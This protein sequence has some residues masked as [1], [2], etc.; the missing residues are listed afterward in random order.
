MVR[1]DNGILQLMLGGYNGLVELLMD[2]SLELIESERGGCCP[3]VFSFF[4][5]RFVLFIFLALFFL[6]YIFCFS[7]FSFFLKKKNFLS[8]N[9]SFQTKFYLLFFSLFFHYIFLSIKYFSHFFSL[10]LPFFS[11]KISPNFFLHITL[12]Y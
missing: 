4:F 8:L 1:N 12:L 10:L 7:S 5:F 6:F 3:V 9:L 11:V 2:L